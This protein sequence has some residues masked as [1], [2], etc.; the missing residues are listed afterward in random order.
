MNDALGGAKLSIPGKTSPLVWEPSRLHDLLSGRRRGLGATLLR[1]GL[2]LAETPYA[3][4]MRWRNHRYDSG[5]AGVHRLD[6]PVIS[7]GNLTT[8]GTGK[9]PLVFWLAQWFRGR[10]IPVAVVSRGYRAPQSGQRGDHGEQAENDEARELAARLPDVPTCRIRSRGGGPASRPPVPMR[11]D[12]PRRRLPAPP[13]RPRPGHRRLGRP[14][15]LG[16]RPPPSPGFAPRAGGRAAA[17][18]SGGPVRA[19]ALAPHQREE[20]HR[21]IAQIAPAG[22]LAGNGRRSPGRRSPRPGGRAHR[23]V[24]RPAGGR[25]LWHWQPR[26]LS[27][28]LGQLRLSGGRVSRVSRP[29][30]LYAPRPGSPGTRGPPT[31]G[32][33]PCSALKRTL[34]SC[35]SIGLATCRSGPLPST[36]KFSLDGSFWRHDWTFW[37]GNPCPLSHRER[38]RARACLRVPARPDFWHHEGTV[39]QGERVEI[40][41]IPPVIAYFIPVH[42]DCPNFRS[43]AHEN[44][45]VPLGRRGQAPFSAH[46]GPKNEPVPSL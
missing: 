24:P 46:N 27:P 12:H 31:A 28:Y 36:W 22:G 45:T 41:K 14:G 17:G 19:D 33:L 13:H 25:V 2:R 40:G 15:A 20:L 39:S 30:C 32:R 44:G 34:S 6:V 35:P 1:G 37:Q 42:G 38:V 21:Q 18:R 4:A 43:E 7:V 11:G 3:W 26:R 16:L 9:T 8:G 10:A 29:S 5:A 23:V